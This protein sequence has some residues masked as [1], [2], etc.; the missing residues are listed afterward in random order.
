MLKKKIIAGLGAALALFAGCVPDE[1]PSEPEPV[2]ITPVSTATALYNVDDGPIRQVGTVQDAETTVT[3]SNLAGH[4]VYL[5]KV[6]RGSASVS[7]GRTGHAYTAGPAQNIRAA[8]LPDWPA[9][10][11]TSRYDGGAVGN[12]MVRRAH[13]EAQRYN[14]NP[15]LYG[16][17]RSLAAPRSAGGTPQFTVASVNDTRQFHVE[18]AQ[19]GWIQITATLRAQS[20]KANVWIPN[21]SFDDSSGSATDNKITTAQ[22]EAMANKFDI[23]YGYETPIFGFE[24][25]GGSGG[26]Y[27]GQ[28][29]GGVDG[30]P[31]VQIL[32]YDIDYDA[33]VSKSSFVVG[34]FWGKDMEV[35]AHSNQAELFYMD[36]EAT[37]NNPSLA[38][39]TLVH[40][41]QHMI[42]FNRKYMLHDRA[43]ATWFDEMLSMVA[44]DMI[45]P[46]IGIPANDQGHPIQGRVPPFLAVYDRAGITQWNTSNPLVSYSI[47][48][49][50]GAY[51]AR[52]YGGANLVKAIMDDNYVDDAAISNG[53]TATGAITGSSPF[54]DA[55]QHYGEALIFSGNRKPSGAKVFDTTSTVQIPSGTGATYTFSAFDIWNMENPLTNQNGPVI[56]SLDWKFAMQP[57]SIIVQSLNEWQNVTGDLRI[58]VNGPAINTVKLYLMVR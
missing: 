27:T 38:Y 45:S 15:R 33:G 50:F 41:F 14:S 37:D 18:N 58:T 31:R 28:P 29:S 46:L 22:A 20:N 54:Q 34:Y 2:P 13:L 44:E 21:E 5:V 16:H 19:G 25:G 26:I 40:E 30:D 56:W 48:Y 47:A 53:L 3:L 49:S 24:Y 8:S 39:S 12:G 52:N 4:S 36:S 32:V 10:S 11:G 1:S 43:S 23:I 7:A 57:Y 17:G 35:G 51:L 42:N 9:S 6:N 55:L